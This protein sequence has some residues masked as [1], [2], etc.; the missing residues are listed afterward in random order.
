MRNLLF[1]LFVFCFSANFAFSQVEG[2]VHYTEEVENPNAEE[3]RERLKDRGMR[4]DIPDSHTSKMQLFFNSKASV[5]KQPEEDP[6]AEPQDRRMRWMMRRFGGGVDVNGYFRNLA[7]KKRLQE[8]EIMGKK[9][10][11]KDDEFNYEWK[12]T[13]QKQQIGQYEVM[14]AVT[15]NETDTIQAWFT[16]Q[17]PVATGPAEFSQL[18]GLILRV[19]VNGGER[20]ISATNIDLRPLTE[21]EAIEEPKKGKEVTEEE[22]V[23]IRQEKFEEVRDLY[24]EERANEIFRD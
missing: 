23:Q 22:F 20:L 16:P 5:Y 18:P 15:S 9:F 10:L 13:G 7:E 8:K 14:E 3:M 4:I 1:V 12:I 21:D 19:S 24:G 6:T 11:I 17:I 2:V